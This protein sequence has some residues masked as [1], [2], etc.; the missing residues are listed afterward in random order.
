MDENFPLKQLNLAR[1]KIY[2]NAKLAW[3]SVQRSE[4]KNERAKNN[5][6]YVPTMKEHLGNIVTHGALVVPVAWLS[7]MMMQ[8]AVGPVQ[9][10][11][12]AVYGAVLT[13][14]F[15][16]STVF[17]VVSATCEDGFWRELLHRSDRAMIYLF[18]AGAYTPWLNLKHLSGL[19]V[20]LRW[21]VWI[22]ATI[23]ILYQQTFHERYK[24]VETTFYVIIALL[25]SLSV[26]EMRDVS[27]LTELKFGG[28]IYAVG[29]LFFKSDGRIPLAHAIWHLHVVLGALIHFY[30]VNKYLVVPENTGPFS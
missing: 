17:H 12:S 5:E 1:Q 21:T 23:G 29:V 22:L 19:S 7:Y 24:A 6:Q 30:A 20:E 10:Y 16:V 26:W 9:A 3:L 2:L 8:S 11:A 27:G 15:S 13:G 25:P 14:L 4:W 28:A 18:I